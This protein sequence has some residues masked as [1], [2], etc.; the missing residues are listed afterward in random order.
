VV[1]RAYETAGRPCEA[2]I[3]VLGRTVPVTFGPAE[4]RTFLVP[5]DPSAPVVETDLIE[6]QEEPAH[7][8]SRTEEPRPGAPAPQAGPEE[9]PH[10]IHAGVVATDTVQ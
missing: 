6:W 1:V 3:E 7:Q 10:P 9:T 4:I 5:R 2:T 8:E